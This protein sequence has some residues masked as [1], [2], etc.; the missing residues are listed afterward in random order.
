MRSLLNFTDAKTIALEDEITYLTDYLDLEKFSR[1]ETFDYK[2]SKD[3]SDEVYLP[4]MLIQPFLENA[5][6]HGFKGIQYP[7]MIQISF[8]EKP[9]YLVA[10][11]LDNGIGINS[12][13]KNQKEKT[14]RS[15]ALEITENRLKSLSKFKPGKIKIEDLSEKNTSGTGTS[16]IID[17]PI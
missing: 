14:H 1:N 3:V 8:H 5:I 13:I 6:V 4:P 10:E 7:G 9:G 12:S 16:V 17:I 15:M 2:I 11:I